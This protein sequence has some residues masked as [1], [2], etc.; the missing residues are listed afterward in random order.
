VNCA[1]VAAI[2]SLETAD[3][4]SFDRVFGTVVRGAFNLTRLLAPALIAARGNVVNV[5]SVAAT[6]VH[7]GSL[8]YGM[9]KVCSILQYLPDPPSSSQP[10]L[11]SARTLFLGRVTYFYPILL[12]QILILVTVP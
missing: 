2:T 9:A 3:M 11:I 1:G 7:V 5:S 6:M 12:W 10:V 8:P 4:A